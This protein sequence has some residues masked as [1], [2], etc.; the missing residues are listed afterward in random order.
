[1]DPEEN[2]KRIRERVAEINDPGI[3]KAEWA[4]AASDLAALVQSLDE[5][6]S[7]GGFAPRAWRVPI[8]A[9]FRPYESGAE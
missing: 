8:H 1:M 5:W 2:L 4:Y 9:G 6:L 3:S 7:S